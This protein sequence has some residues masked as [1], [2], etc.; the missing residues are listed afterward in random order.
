MTYN[1]EVDPKVINIQR[2]N[3]NENKMVELTLKIRTITTLI[4]MEC[5]T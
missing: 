5:H 2:N 1:R 3:N 4:I